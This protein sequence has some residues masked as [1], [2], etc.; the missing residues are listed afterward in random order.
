[1]SKY[2]LA[3]SISALTAIALSYIC[4]SEE[5]FCYDNCRSVSVNVILTLTVLDDDIEGNPSIL[6]EETTQT[7]NNNESFP[8]ITYR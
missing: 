2:F 8:E 5:S 4:K 7:N 1:M 6:R 3:L